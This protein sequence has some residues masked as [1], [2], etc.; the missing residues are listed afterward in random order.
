MK[1][2]SCVLVLRYGRFISNKIRKSPIPQLCNIFIRF[3]QKGV[4]LFFDGYYRY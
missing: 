2:D 1:D 4:E 3:E